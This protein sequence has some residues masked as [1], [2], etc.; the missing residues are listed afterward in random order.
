MDYPI[1]FPKFIEALRSLGAEPNPSEILTNPRQA[2]L[3]LPADHRLA[4]LEALGVGSVDPDAVEARL[5]KRPDAPRTLDNVLIILRIPDVAPEPETEAEALSPSLEAA[6]E[7]EGPAI[8]AVPEPLHAAP[9]PF[10]ASAPEPV[11]SFAP[12]LEPLSA[13]AAEAA[14]GEESLL[15]LGD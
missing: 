11:P 4:L 1:E 6:P 15:P 8:E 13:A 12:T 5:G 3:S 2:W 10:E 14:P 7:P 9:S